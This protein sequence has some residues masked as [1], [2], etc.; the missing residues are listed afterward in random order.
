MVSLFFVLYDRS[1]RQTM[2]GRYIVFASKLANYTAPCRLRLAIAQNDTQSRY[3]LINGCANRI[4]S[5][6][7]L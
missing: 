4:I 2:Q 1:A 7:R 6:A 5:I 3:S